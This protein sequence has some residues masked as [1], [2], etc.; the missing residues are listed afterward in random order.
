[1]TDKQRTLAETQ[2]KFF[3]FAMEAASIGE[4]NLDLH[5]GVGN[6]SAH[7]ARCFGY[8]DGP[9]EW[10]FRKFMRHVHPDDRADVR[11]SIRA[12]I[13]RMKDWHS[14]CR[15]IWPDGSIHWIGLR[16]FFPR[17]QGSAGRVM[18]IATDIT[19]QR[20][21]EQARLTLQR[22]EAEKWRIQEDGRLRSQF[23]AN[24]SHALRTPLNAIIG[25][26]D[27][28]SSGTVSP[29]SPKHRAFLGHIATGGRQLL[30]LVNDILD[31][32][33]AE[34]GNLEFSPGAL[35]LPGLV[36]E[37]VGELQATHPSKRVD[38]A[39]DIDPTLT[40]LELD[41]DRLRQVL[42]TYLSTAM[43]F[44]ASNGPVTMRGRAQGTAQFRIE[45]EVMGAGLEE[46]DRLRLFNEFRQF[47][48]GFNRQHQGS[49]LGMVL[50]RRLIEAQG[51]TVGV[52]DVAGKGSVVHFILNRVHGARPSG[53]DH[54]L[55]PPVKRNG[56]RLLV[57]QDDQHDQPGLT[58]ELSAAGFDVDSASTGQQAVLR[59][60]HNAYDAIALDLLLSDQ[61]ALKVLETIRNEGP[62]RES[63]VVSVSIAADRG[64][65]ATFAI[66]NVLCKPINNE[67]IAH[68]MRRFLSRL[69]RTPRVM[70]IDD[71]PMALDLMRTTLASL[72]IECIG[73]SDGRQALKDIGT[74]R[75]DALILD[76]MMPDFD[77][78][79]VLDALRRIPVWRD[80]PVFIWTSM[81][82]T[83]EEYAS[84][85]RSAHDIL[86]KGGG[87]LETMVDDLRNRRQ[88]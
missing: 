31:L 46:S 77:G 82:L 52:S 38:I 55:V 30:Q 10:T 84:L 73:L 67:E 53:A 1:M 28:L 20:L 25:F 18:G 69:P 75:P 83:S 4:W 71:D 3:R 78:F 70:V 11:R 54:A 34:A 37:V 80:T 16:G 36:R 50:C 9:G 15:V 8:G 40:D 21:A 19:Q 49:D 23:L 13:G 60:N 14:E 12:D 35:H 65:A 41:S 44:A 6:Y 47:D 43:K 86:S 17:D 32:S 72:G 51:G 57:I 61:S 29:E 58:Y 79:A 76:L 56:Q 68:A 62:N 59:A 66:A 26:S 85:K 63:P 27:L 48:A 33:R 88:G 39:V 22:L 64:N 42:R 24:M 81:T 7:L 45:V 5:T 74:H 2:D 87:A